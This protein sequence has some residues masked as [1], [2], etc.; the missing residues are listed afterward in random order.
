MNINFWKQP[1]L[2]RVNVPKS[3]ENEEVDLIFG[4]V[5]ESTQPTVVENNPIETNNDNSFSAKKELFSITPNLDR[6]DVDKEFFEHP[7]LP[8]EVK[9][10]FIENN[11]FPIKNIYVPE[12]VIRGMKKNNINSHK[13]Q[14]KT[15]QKHVNR[16]TLDSIQA[17]L[18]RAFTDPDYGMS[19]VNGNWF[20]YTLF[21]TPNEVF[22]SQYSKPYLSRKGG[23]L[24]EFSVKKKNPILIKE[25]DAKKLTE[26]IL[27]INSKNGLREAHKILENLKVDGIIY[28]SDGTAIAWMNP[29]S[30]LEL[31]RVI[32]R[33]YEDGVLK[34]TIAFEKK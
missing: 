14:I 19:G 13:N 24:S 3:K 7:E 12:M 5:G 30:T 18:R 9:R 17:K 10:K 28:E 11:I 8:E 25:T 22:A 34:E 2:E 4:K 29:E 26:N 6:I 32:K 16:I 23:V 31:K 33:K 27:N 20:G 15:F 1:K 21:T